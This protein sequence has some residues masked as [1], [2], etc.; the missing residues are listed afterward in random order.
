MP[1]HN[2]KAVMNGHP[3]FA[4]AVAVVFA[5]AVAVLACHSRR[6]SASAFAVAFAF[7]VAVLVCHSRRE[8]ASAFAFAFL[9]VIPR[10]SERTCFLPFFVRVTQKIVCNNQAD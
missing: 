1:T 10:R 4:V 9:V 6:E 8:S 7:A 2:D 5:L 3:A